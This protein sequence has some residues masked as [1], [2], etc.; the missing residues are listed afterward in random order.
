MGDKINFVNISKLKNPKP[1]NVVKKIS[2]FQITEQ[3]D[4]KKK[5]RLDSIDEYYLDRN[6]IEKSKVGSGDGAARKKYNAKSI[7]NI[8]TLIF[9]KTDQSG[10]KNDLIDD[11]ITYFKEEYAPR[12]GIIANNTLVDTSSGLSSGVVINDLIHPIYNVNQASN[13]SEKPYSLL[14]D[15]DDDDDDSP[16]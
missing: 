1:L 16:Y 3:E 8:H 11:V 14:Y 12:V 5:S 15:S 4:L 2:N 6:T 7:S 13:V 9:G 10:K